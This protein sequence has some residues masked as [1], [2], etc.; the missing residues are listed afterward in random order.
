M[1]DWILN[2]VR[3]MVQPL[4]IMVMMGKRREK[5]KRLCKGKPDL[6]PYEPFVPYSALLKAKYLKRESKF[7]KLL[8]NFK[9]SHLNVLCA[10]DIVEMPSCIKSIKEILLKLKVLGTKQFLTCLAQFI[11]VRPYVIWGPIL[12]CCLLCF[13]R[14]EA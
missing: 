10:N 2:V 3:M 12:I 11:F 1:K 7:S 8:E 5:I 13:S 14:V 6:K 9:K 4:L